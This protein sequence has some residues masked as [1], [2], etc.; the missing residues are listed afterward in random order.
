MHPE[1]R[2]G[3]MPRTCR[4]QVDDG[5]GDVLR[6]SWRAERQPADLGDVVANGLPARQA[7]AL[8]D[9]VH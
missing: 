2:S 7:L 1:Q 6:R 9:P 8:H 5:V 3:H 4:E